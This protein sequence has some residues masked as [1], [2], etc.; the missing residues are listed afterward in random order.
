MKPF[1]EWPLILYSKDV[2]ACLGIGRNDAAA[3]LKTAPVLNPDKIRYRAITK[4]ELI[5]FLEGESA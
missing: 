1:D 3:I 4:K 2:E 5:K